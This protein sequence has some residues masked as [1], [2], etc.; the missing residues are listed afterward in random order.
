M[1]IGF[2]T[3]EYPHHSFGNSGGIGTS[4]KSLAISLIN[5]GHQVTIILYGQKKD[6]AVT[7]DGIHFITVKNPKLKGLSWLLLRLK[8]QIIINKEIETGNIEVLEVS[9][10]TGIS[11]FM[12]LKCPVAMRL[13]GTDTVFCYL[14]N[15]IVKSWNKYLEGNALKKADGIIAVS[16]FIGKQTNLVFKHNF[17]YTVIFN[18]IN[19]SEFQQTNNTSQNKVILYFGTL[20]RK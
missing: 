9:D 2:L 1:K 20:I 3:S 12:N 18:G 16:D 7:V 10:W 19:P 15:R 8:L 11:A 14:D 13:H 17:S 6:D 4:I 5:L